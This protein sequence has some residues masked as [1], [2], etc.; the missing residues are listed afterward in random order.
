MVRDTHSDC[1]PPAMFKRRFTR[2]DLVWHFRANP[3]QDF[4]FA[5]QSSNHPEVIASK[6]V[7]LIERGEHNPSLNLA[8]SIANALGSTLSEMVKEAE[9]LRKRQR[10]E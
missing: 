9:T 2:V 4:L 6:M 1:R 7:S 8:D 10:Q 3:P 5:H